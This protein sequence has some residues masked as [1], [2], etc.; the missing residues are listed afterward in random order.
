MIRTATLLLAL[1]A[2]L[3]ASA[4]DDGFLGLHEAGPRLDLGDFSLSFSGIADVEF[5]STDET[6]PGLLLEDDS[7][8][9]PRLTVFADASYGEHWSALLQARADDG[10]DPQAVGHLD[11]RL[12]EAFVRGTWEVGGDWS[13][14]AQAG[15]FATPLGNWVPR[16]DPM[17]NPFVRAPIVYDHV[18]TIGDG[19]PV[20]SGA[21]LLSR[22]D[23]P[24]KKLDWVSMLWGPVYHSGVLLFAASKRADLRLA[25]TNAAPC[26]RPD[27]WTWQGGDRDHLAW[28][29]RASW[30]PTIGLRLGLNAAKGPYLRR[31][32]ED[33]LPASK[34][35]SKYDQSLVGIDAEYGIGHFTA[36]AEV[37]RT[38]WDVTNVADHPSALGWYVEGRYAFFPGFFACARVGAIHF[39]RI[40]VGGAEH[41]WERDT[42]RFEVGAGYRIY[43]NLLVKA[44][45]EINRTAGPGDPDD[46]LLSV[47]AA[48]S[49]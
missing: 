6:A 4:Q 31:E 46:D 5:Y 16:H 49:W 20:P 12:D 45:Y 37:Y 8:F 22:R 29:G 3:P 21:G 19:K 26:E 13:F 48:L 9:S 7:F 35:R 38:T 47:A 18:T 27:E 39:G 34:D 33:L 42:R 32:I 10:F 1:A 41:K 28:S 36:F 2:A 14:S 25:L 23:I 11:L 17:K 24:D 44:Q 30:V 40:D 15:K 43:V